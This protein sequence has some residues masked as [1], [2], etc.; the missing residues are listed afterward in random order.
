MEMKNKSRVNNLVAAL[1]ERGIDVSTEAFITR[2]PSVQTFIFVHDQKIIE[3]CDKIGKF[4]AMPN[5]KY[6]FLGYRDTDKVKERSD[7]IIAR[8]QPV[9]I[10]SKKNLVAWTGWYSVVKNGHASADI[11]N[12]FEYDIN[13]IGP[14]TQSTSSCGYIGHPGMDDVWWNYADIQPFVEQAIG[15]KRSEVDAKYSSIPVPMTSNYTLSMSL[16][17]L[18]VKEM[19]GI[20]YD[21][22]TMCGHIIERH[23]SQ[24]MRDLHVN[25]GKISH[26]Y[27]D[28]HKT[29]GG[30]YEYED[31]RHLVMNNLGSRWMHKGSLS[32]SDVRDL[33][34]YGLKT[35]LEIG[36]NC[37]Q[38]TVEFA[39]LMP[40]ATI[41][42]FEP[43]PRA[44]RK[45]KSN[46]SRF[47]KNDIRLFEMAIGAKNGTIPFFQS[48]GL[49]H[50][51]EF[52]EGWDHSGSIKKPKNHLEVYPWVKFENQ[53]DVPIMTL[54]SWGQE[55]SIGDVDFIWADVQGAEADMISGAQQTLKR[56]KYLYTEY[57]NDEHYDG[58]V[59]LSDI[60]KMLPDFRI[61][62]IFENDVLLINIKLMDQ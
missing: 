44:I 34:G 42:C 12:L 59:N 15:K 61:L 22:N 14:W 28:S 60:L 53:I 18:F 23:C 46:M 9:N 39:K 13:M 32:T 35:I 8:D 7:V 58:Q 56:T 52:K 54:D 11:I 50:V 20:R 26:L 3:D 48:A 21:G 36:A 16:L 17:E 40:S 27:F 24:F 25:H 2:E 38:T 57:S 19:D 55:N 47:E 51:E 31:M 43:D 10:E 37:G 29:Q 5:V 49:E 1:K 62:K 33:V 6:V 45:F 30:L 4:S 41:C